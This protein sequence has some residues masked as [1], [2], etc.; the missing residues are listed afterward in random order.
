MFVVSFVMAPPS[1]ESEPPTNP[2][3]FKRHL[4]DF[5]SAYNFGRRLKTLKGLTQYEFICKRWTV[6][7][8]KFRLNPLHQ[9]PGLNI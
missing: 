4:A 8:V 9:M 5:V 3:Q 1:Q 6:E 2:G 7:P